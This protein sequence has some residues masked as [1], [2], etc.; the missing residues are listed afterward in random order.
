MGYFFKNNS[1]IEERHNLKRRDKD[2][3]STNRDRKA[4]KY[5]ESGEYK[6][7]KVGGC[8]WSSIGKIVDYSDDSIAN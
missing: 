6:K 2:R 8:W 5:V 4:G 1:K 3:K 7:Y